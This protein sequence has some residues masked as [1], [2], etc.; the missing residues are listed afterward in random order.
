MASLVF[1]RYPNLLRWST[2]PPY[3]SI[4]RLVRDKR[5]AGFGEVLLIF[6]QFL[7]GLS[8]ELKRPKL[9][10]AIFNGIPN[11]MECVVLDVLGRAGYSWNDKNR[12][13][14]SARDTRV[15]ALLSVI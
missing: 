5:H 4:G 9:H 6:V 14:C 11:Y 13:T 10:N 12:P 1:R 2:P 8:I 7:S 15:Q 3:R